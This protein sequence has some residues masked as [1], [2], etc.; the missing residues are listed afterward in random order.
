MEEILKYD[1]IEGKNDQGSECICLPR[2][3]VGTV[4]NRFLNN[5]VCLSHNYYL[6]KS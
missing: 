6:T 1:K 5:L 2:S 4:P 3:L